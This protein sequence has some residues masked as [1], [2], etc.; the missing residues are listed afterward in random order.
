MAGA[1]ISQYGFDWA[2]CP[3][4]LWQRVPHVAVIMLALLAAMTFEEH[5]AFA[6]AL[7]LASVVALFANAGVGIYH[8][9][10]ERH[11]IVP[12]ETC[13]NGGIGGGFDALKAQ[14]LGAK[15]ARCDVP[16]E[17]FPGFTM[18]NANVLLCFTLAAFGF[19]RWVRE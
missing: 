10:V 4:C 13:T 6:R 1:L 14:L 8:S 18:A 5:P 11:I 2:P 3:L 17:F 19:Q 16:A 12:M 15:A 7:L 9:L